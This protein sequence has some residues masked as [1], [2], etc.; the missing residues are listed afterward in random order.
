MNKLYF[1]SN[2]KE[3]KKTSLIRVKKRSKIRI[4]LITILSSFCELGVNENQI[5][6]RSFTFVKSH[7]T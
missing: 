7:K 5:G 1:S 2:D 6:I 4:F 3:R